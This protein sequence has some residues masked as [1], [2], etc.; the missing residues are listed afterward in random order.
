MVITAPAFSL[1]IPFAG[2]NLAIDKLCD[3]YLKLLKFYVTVLVIYNCQDLDRKFNGDFE[4]FCSDPCMIDVC[5][6]EVFTCI[7]SIFPDAYSVMSSLS[8]K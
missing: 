7:K 8:R 1:S 3:K 5:Y 2:P 4:D 6:T